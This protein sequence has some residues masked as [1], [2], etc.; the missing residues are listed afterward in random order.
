ML[1]AVRCKGN[2]PKNQS[3]QEN[4]LTQQSSWEV[5]QG[6]ANQR[7][8]KTKHFN[9]AFGFT[10]AAQDTAEHW[11]TDTIKTRFGPGANEFFIG[12]KTP[13]AFSWS[14]FCCETHCF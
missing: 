2:E 4:I 3:K 14:F 9:G 7:E 6:G 12:S 13:H 10:A 1:T 8:G 11:I 5:P